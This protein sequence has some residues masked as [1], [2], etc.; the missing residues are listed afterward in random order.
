MPLI[1]HFMSSEGWEMDDLNLPRVYSQKGDT[2]KGK[3]LALTVRP[4]IHSDPILALDS[5][6]NHSHQEEHRDDH[7]DDYHTDDEDSKI[8]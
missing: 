3:E 5:D 8:H 7:S 1:K 4:R 2:P 6:Y